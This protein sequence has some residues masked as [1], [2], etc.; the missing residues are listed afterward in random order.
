MNFHT[1]GQS[2]V[3]ECTCGATKKQINSCFTSCEALLDVD[4][5]MKL[6]ACVP[7]GMGGAGGAGGSGG[8][9]SWQCKTIGVGSCGC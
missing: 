7:G 6:G 3:C 1:M 5:N 8:S 2:N 9:A 4:K